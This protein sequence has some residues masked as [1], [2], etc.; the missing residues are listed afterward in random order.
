MWDGRESY[1][2][3]PVFDL[4]G[5]FY[6][7]QKRQQ[8]IS[9]RLANVFDREYATSLGNGVLDSTGGGYTYWN[10]GVPRTFEARYTWHF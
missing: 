1:G 7:D 4:A 10:V 6:L 2:E 3:Y 8:T 5:R 9:F